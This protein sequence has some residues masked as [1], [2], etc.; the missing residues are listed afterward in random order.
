[1]ENIRPEVSKFISAYEHLFSFTLEMGKLTAD[2]CLALEY[3]AGE[4]RKQ[5]APA[6]SDPHAHCQEPASSPS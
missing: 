5:I 4:L 1:M 6:C 2:E 3:Y